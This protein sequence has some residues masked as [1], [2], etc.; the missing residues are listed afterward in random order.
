MNKKM[1]KQNNFNQPYW[2]FNPQSFTHVTSG[3][4]GGGGGVG[5]IKERE[6][7][8][9]LTSCQPLK[10]SLQ[11]NKHDIIGQYMFK[12]PVMSKPKEICIIKEEEEI[13]ER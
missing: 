1:K 5:G 8:W 11:S 2:G 12:A 13:E 4:G 6:S 9:I 10:G 3:R 7:N